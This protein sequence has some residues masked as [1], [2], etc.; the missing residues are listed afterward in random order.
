MLLEDEK[1]FCL[2][3]DGLVQIFVKSTRD[4]RTS[5]GRFW[6]NGGEG[7]DKD[8]GEHSEGEH[9]GYQLLTE[10]KNGAPMSSLFS[11]LSLFTENVKLRHDQE[12]DAR[13][14]SSASSGGF[15]PLELQQ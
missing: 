7:L 8:E 1:G 9:Q 15:F 13:P 4:E 14:A 12:Q 3:V 2:V 11:V 6:T 5:D 10:V